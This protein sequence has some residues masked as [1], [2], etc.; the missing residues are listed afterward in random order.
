MFKKSFKIAAHNPLSGK[1]KKKLRQDLS[2]SFDPTSVEL[3]LGKND[4]E[5]FCDKLQGA[6]TLIFTANDIPIFADATGKGTY[7]PTG[8]LPPYLS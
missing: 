6:K 8:L 1:D 4:V 3:L 2:K 7:L 5:V